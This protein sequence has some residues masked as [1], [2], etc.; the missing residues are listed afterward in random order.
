VA[1]TMG[2]SADFV[3]QIVDL[4]DPKRFWWV[5]GDLLGSPRIV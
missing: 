5:R 2:E 3:D 4:W 1:E